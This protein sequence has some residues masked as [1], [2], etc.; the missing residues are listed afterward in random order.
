M[1]YQAHVLKVLIASPSDT[2]DARSAVDAALHGWNGSRSE[3]EQIILFP[4]LWERHAVPRLGGSAQSIINAQAVDDAD[5]VIALFDSRLGEATAEAVS[6]TAE[7]ITRADSAGKPVHVYFSTEPLPRD[8]DPDQLKALKTFKDQLKPLGLLGEYANPDDLG[9]QVRNAIED[10]LTKLG[11]GNV[12]PIKRAG[13]H[14]VPRLHVE[15]TREQTGTDRKTGAAKFTNR[16]KLV[17]ENKSETV[18]AEGLRMGLGEF[19]HSVIRQDDNPVDLP[20]LVSLSWPLA[21]SMGSPDQV[22]VDL[23]WTEGGDPQRLTVPLSTFG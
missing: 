18:T 23:E 15:K 4:W 17:L 19:A 22:N 14:A 12:T 3:R 6:G 8:A 11:L 7:E 9:Y 5:I 1:T 20:P 10:D 13:L 16:Y 2:A 21:L